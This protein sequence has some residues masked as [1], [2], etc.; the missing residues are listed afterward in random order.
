[1]AG[2]EFRHNTANHR[3]EAWLDGEL[4]GEAT[5][6]LHDGV[7]DFDHTFVEPEQRHTGVAGRLVQYAFDEVKAAG[8]WKIRPVCPYVTSWA[9]RHPEYDDL[10]VAE[11]SNLD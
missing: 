8:R 3:F 10:L 11:V 9:R 7:A 4:I 1:V 2:E 5:Y 6:W